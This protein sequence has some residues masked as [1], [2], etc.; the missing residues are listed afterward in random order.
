MKLEDFAE[1]TMKKLGKARG[2]ELIQA[3]IMGNRA[4][5]SSKPIIKEELGS[6]EQEYKRFMI[7]CSWVKQ[8]CFPHLK[9]EQK[10]L[11]VIPEIFSEFHHAY[12]VLMNPYHEFLN[13][14]KLTESDFSENQELAFHTQDACANLYANMFLEPIP[15]YYLERVC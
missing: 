2:M 14:L 7:L 11:F 10:F 5:A 4:L 9:K 12:K 13:L 8:D 3:H 6:L 15:E 1:Q